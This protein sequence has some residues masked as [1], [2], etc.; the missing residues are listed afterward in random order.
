M[1]KLSFALL[2]FL[3]VAA[4]RIHHIDPD[5]PLTVSLEY[6]S[7][8]L[9]VNF[10]IQAADKGLLRVRIRDQN[11]NIVFQKFLHGSNQYKGTLNLQNLING[12][13]Y[14]EVRQS[15]QKIV[16]HISLLETSL[17]SVSLK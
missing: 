1:P 9:G 16:R 3:S 2:I 17:R 7:D 13:Y 10:Y 4:T 8:A 15:H 11:R 14:I 5:K 12:D 6:A